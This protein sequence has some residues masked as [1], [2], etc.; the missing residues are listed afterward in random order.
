MFV[1]TA[2]PDQE[3]LLQDCVRTCV[4]IVYGMW[5]CKIVRMCQILVYASA[6]FMK[7]RFFVWPCSSRCVEFGFV[8][9]CQHVDAGMCE[10]VRICICLVSVY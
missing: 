8:C 10:C 9:L 2:C 5:C 7:L 1:F 6:F 4:N 3:L